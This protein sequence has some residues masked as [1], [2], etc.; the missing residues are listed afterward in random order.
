[1]FVRPGPHRPTLDE[2]M[3]VTA[4]QLTLTFAADSRFIATVRLTAASIAA[5]FGFDVDDIED[6]RVAAN[7]LFAFLVETAEDVGGDQ[8][9]I[10]IHPSDHDISIEGRVLGVNGT[11]HDVPA[12]DE[13]TSRI[14]DAVVDTHDFDGAWGRIHK[15]SSS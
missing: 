13:L 5:E 3:P 10:A 15:R 14:L 7:E 11:T 8:V 6:L 4:N 12:V 9:E 2:G 1:M